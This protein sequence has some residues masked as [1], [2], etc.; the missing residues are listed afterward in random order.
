[1]TLKAREDDL[2]TLV[3]PGNEAAATR[4]LLEA[5]QAVQAEGSR[6]GRRGCCYLHCL[7]YGRLGEGGAKGRGEARGKG[8]G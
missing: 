2:G 6:G 1:M 8:S 4:S 7:G 3:E 5:T